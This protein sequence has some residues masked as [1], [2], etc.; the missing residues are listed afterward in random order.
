M[1]AESVTPLWIIFYHIENMVPDPWAPIRGPPDPMVP[2]PWTPHPWAPDHSFIRLFPIHSIIHSF[3]HPFIYSTIHS[4]VHAFIH[5][6]S[7]HLISF[8][9][10]SSHFILFHFIYSVTQNACTIPPPPPMNTHEHIPCIPKPNCLGSF[11]ARA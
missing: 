4:F 5:F 9:I 6:I 7:F 8:H 3:I 10:I 11:A 2:D 1:C